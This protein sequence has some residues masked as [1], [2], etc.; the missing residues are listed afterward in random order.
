MLLLFLL[1]CALLVPV[2]PVRKP[3]MSCLELGALAHPPD[4]LRV[5]QLPRGRAV[6][7]PLLHKPGCIACGWAQTLRHWLPSLEA[8]PNCRGGSVWNAQG[9]C[10]GAWPEGSPTIECDLGQHDHG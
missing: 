10:K 3:C 8:T 9:G 7:P 2:A 1:V 5:P 4:I 6:G